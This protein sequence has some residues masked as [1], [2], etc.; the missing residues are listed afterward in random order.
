M[1]R[2]KARNKPFKPEDYNATT[3]PV[4]RVVLPS[5]PYP[6]PTYLDGDALNVPA[7][8]SYAR[9]AP[10][11]AYPYYQPPQYAVYPVYPVLPDAPNKKYRGSPPGGSPPA[12]QPARQRRAHRSPLPG[13][14]GLCLFLVQMVLLAR[15][16]CLLFNV[17]DTTLWLALL[18]AAGDLFVEPLRVLAANINLSVLAGTQLLTILEFL[19]AILAYGLLS[20]ILVRL[21]KMLLNP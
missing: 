15:V 4:E 10:D 6:A 5:Y 2:Q 20:R 3:E 16:G 14:V 12:P 1:R 21:L 11:E 18:F 17:Q 13:L 9:P 8:Q 19:V 7:A